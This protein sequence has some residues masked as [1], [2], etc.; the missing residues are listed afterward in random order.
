MEDDWWGAYGKKKKGKKGKIQ[1]TLVEEP[2]APSL[3]A[4][5]EPEYKICPDRD[6]HLNAYLARA[7]HTDEDGYEIMHPVLIE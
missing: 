1:E 7:D 4:V 2:P 5:P 6:K 3:E